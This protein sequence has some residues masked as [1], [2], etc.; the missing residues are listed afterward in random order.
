MLIFFKKKGKQVW[1]PLNFIK[2]NLKKGQKHGSKN[3]SRPF[4]CHLIQS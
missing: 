1:E 3:H 4:C 2:I